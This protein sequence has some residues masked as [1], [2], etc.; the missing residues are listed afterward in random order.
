[1]GD[2]PGCHGGTQGPGHPLLTRA[3]AGEPASHT[4]TL[5]SRTRRSPHLTPGPSAAQTGM[6]QE[7][8]LRG[9]CRKQ[10]KQCLWGVG[11]TCEL[12]QHSGLCAPGPPETPVD[13]EASLRIPHVLPNHTADS[14]PRREAI[15][16]PRGQCP[17]ARVLRERRTRRRETE[18]DME[19]G[20]RGNRG[21]TP[22]QTPAGQR[23][24]QSSRQGQGEEGSEGR[25]RMERVCL[26]P[27]S[28]PLHD[29]GAAMPRG[30]WRRG[31]VPN[32]LGLH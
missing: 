19:D 31:A 28:A 21:G 7:S 11:V 24:E 2:L 14:R 25:G 26:S 8:Q 15:R 16:E 23:D 9:S 3:R 32:T 17:E 22:T 29:L 13:S 20:H 6:E 18:T 12:P 30:G 5:A 1:M 27:S 10:S 4:D